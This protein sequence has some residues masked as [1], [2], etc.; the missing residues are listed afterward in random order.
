MSLYRRKDSSVWWVKLSHRGQVIQRSAG[1]TDKVAAQEYHDRLKASLWEQDKLGA[2]P[3]YSWNDA[4]VRWLAETQHKATQH[5]DKTH[6]RWLDKYLGG[7]PLAEI[8]RD[9]IDAII[10]ARLVDKVANGTVNRTLAVIR[11]VLRKAALEWEWMNRYPK[12]RLLPEPRR[13]VRWLTTEEAARLIAELPMHLAEMMCFT[14]E[15]GL[16][17]ANVTGLQWSQVDMMRRCAWIHPD[18][19]KARKAIA[20]PL[21]TGALDLLQE[22]VGKHPEH[23]FSYRGKCITQVNTKAWHNALQRAG[24]EN[25]RWHD[26]RHTWASWHVQAGTPLHA[27]QELGAWESVE[28]VRRYAHLSSEHLS[29]YV[30]RRPQVR[31]A[32]YQV[33]AT[34]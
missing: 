19:A 18:Q 34:I 11:A 6:L 9:K 26:L 20:V 4:V 7:L 2:K 24:I 10:K 12:I 15:T 33:G 5:D 28:M 27:L 16:R 23:V 29:Q 17:Q 25:F 30:E 14:L 31:G 8:S 21:S 1:T 32:S 3:R 13:R 22:R